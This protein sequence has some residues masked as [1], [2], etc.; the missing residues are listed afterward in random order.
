MWMKPLPDV[1]DRSPEPVETTAAQSPSLGGGRRRVRI[2]LAVGAPLAALCVLLALV[3]PVRG[4]AVIEYFNV[5][6]SSS[7][8]LL[9]WST[10]SEYNVAGF[11]VLCK[12]TSEPRSAYH[13][14][15]YFPAKGNPTQGAQYDML[16]TDLKPGVAYCFTLR[17]LTTDGEPGET[18]E[19]CGFGLSITPTPALPGGVTSTVGLTPTVV[20][21]PTPTLDP[22]LQQQSPLATPTFDPF[23][24]P[25]PFPTPLGAAP[26]DLLASSADE[27]ARLEQMGM[28]PTPDLMAT[29][30]AA[31]VFPSPTPLSTVDPF[32]ST[33]PVPTPTMTTAAPAA[34]LA[35]DGAQPMTATAAEA[36]QA[37]SAGSQD[38]AG[39]QPAPQDDLARGDLAQADATQQPGVQPQDAQ[40]GGADQSQSAPDG[41]QAAGPTPTPTSLFVVVTAAPAQQSQGIPPAVTPW[42]TATPAPGLQLASLTQPT[43]QNLTV[44]L[45]CAVVFVAGGLGMLGLIT[46]VLYFRSRSQR[47]LDE[48]RRRRR[49]L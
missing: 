44:M 1:E 49:R 43:A 30:M 20:L 28:L 39:Q 45:L 29:S 47:D 18:R 10:A 7:A 12:A 3:L 4:A 48:L 19:R 34:M 26:Q 23:A 13:R 8:V 24:T 38:A 31:S 2:A 14:I 37:Q 33:S 46:S 22:L 25:T 6:S 16:V 40:S 9:E 5:I 42:P 27:Q 15:G 36:A 11:E 21:F 17:E 41:A 32:Q 35:P